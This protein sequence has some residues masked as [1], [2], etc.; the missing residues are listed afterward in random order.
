MAGRGYVARELGLDVAAQMQNTLVKKK[1]PG[2]KTVTFGTEVESAPQ[3]LPPTTSKG[4]ISKTAPI[5]QPIT[6]PKR[7]DDRIS[8]EA[9]V[10]QAVMRVQSKLQGQGATEGFMQLV[11][12]ILNK[13][14]FEAVVEERAATLLCGYPMC[15]EKISNFN[16]EEKTYRISLKDQR[17]YEITEEKLFCGIEC[18][19][20]SMK[21]GSQLTTSNVYVTHYKTVPALLKL[22]P[23]LS[24][25]DLKD[26]NPLIT[27][28]QSDINLKKKVVTAA[29]VGIIV[30]NDQPNPT[31]VQSK[32]GADPSPPV[33]EPAVQK[34]VV[35]AGN[36]KQQPELRKEKKLNPSTG[37]G[38]KDVS[39]DDL[40]RQFAAAKQEMATHQRTT[41]RGANLSDEEEEEEE[42]EEQEESDA[43]SDISDYDDGMD[44]LSKGLDVMLSNLPVYCQ[45]A[46]AVSEWCGSDTSTRLKNKEVIDKRSAATK[47]YNN[48]NLEQ[49]ILD[50]EANT[51]STMGI[52][53]GQEQDISTMRSLAIQ[54]LES[55]TTDVIM[56]LPKFSV[57]STELITWLQ[58]V[59]ETLQPKNTV[60]TLSHR[61]LI[62]LS[63]LFVRYHSPH[64]EDHISEVLQSFGVE[65]NGVRELFGSLETF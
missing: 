6:P 18:H 21:Y 45:V 5:P 52:N 57:P 56:L 11:K 12:G 51:E 32:V 24:L 28:S 30:K 58:Q 10:D 26:I 3:N 29:P 50:E 53:T 34:D 60:L 7:R 1:K 20:A 17:M 39:E 14:K 25:S 65:E 19:R 42:E 27:I 46:E 31:P 38:K 33:A 9:F 62:A 36:L 15:R 54:Q 64:L 22:F 16:L 37:A 35:T 47:D 4:I 55:V 40:W 8:W 61:S 63:L 41:S 49:P 2:R 23:Q 13:Q 48:P 59:Y 44:Y 43:Y